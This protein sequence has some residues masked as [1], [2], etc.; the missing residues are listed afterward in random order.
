MRN[1]GLRRSPVSALITVASAFVVAAAVLVASRDGFVRTEEGTACPA[2]YTSFEELEA[3]EGGGAE[4]E[5]LEG[6]CV[7]NKHPESLAELSI[8]QAERAAM[9]LSAN[10]TFPANARELSLAQRDALAAKAKTDEL[11]HPWKPVGIGPLQS[12]DEGYDSVNGLGLVELAGRI[13]DFSYDKVHDDLYASV[14]SGG[15]WRSDDQGASWVSIGDTL[16]TQVVGSVAYTPAGGGRI[17]A[18]SGDGSFGALSYEGIGA[19][20]S[21][22]G[23]ATWLKATGVPNDAFGFQLAVD[24]TNSKRRLRGDGSGPVPLDRR[25]RD[26]TRT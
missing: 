12:A 11:S 6:L 16:P 9:Y 1:P 17:L 5:G 18:L 26:A 13:T 4:A 20:Y 14:S 19:Y 10:G 23:G 25:R 3:R 7:S 15:V 21:T 24:P 2:G 8:M 22:D